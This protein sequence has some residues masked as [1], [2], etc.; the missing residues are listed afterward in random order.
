MKEFTKSWTRVLLWELEI[1]PAQVLTLLGAFEN[2]EE[3]L[4]Q[5]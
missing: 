3:R 4:H 2:K 1:L 5:E